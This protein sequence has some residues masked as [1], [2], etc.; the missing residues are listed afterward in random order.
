MGPAGWAYADW[1]GKV[2]P[3]D[4]PRSLHPLAYLS[5]FFNTVEV[6]ATFYRPLPARTA[7]PW[8]HHAGGNPDFLFAVKLW[9]VFTH[10]REAWPAATAVQEMEETLKPLAEAGKLGALLAQFP[11]SFRR[12][13]EDRTWLRRVTEAFA[14]YPLVVELRHG[15]W[16]RPEVYAGL[17]ERGVAFCNI[18]QPQIGDSLAPTEVVTAPL[19]YARLHGRNEAD[20][21]REG[22]DRNGRYNYLYSEAELAP[23]RARIKAM[24]AQAARLFV[25]TNNHFEG[26]AVV[27]ALELLHGL[28]HPVQPPPQLCLAYP[29][30]DGLGQA[31]PA[32]TGGPP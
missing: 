31:A 11:W 14:A 20:W 17:R 10:E 3:P 6:N 9:R 7:A 4:M 28:G 21:F 32:E 18:D 16:D 22:A 19:A 1:K 15:S 12:T 24:L 29:R 2:Y 5:R 13:P 8:L 27:N 26:Q 30:L 25:V 23:W